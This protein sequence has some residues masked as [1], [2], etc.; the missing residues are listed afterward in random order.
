MVRMGLF[1]A[2]TIYACLMLELLDYHRRAS[3]HAP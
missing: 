1:V 2:V 3:S